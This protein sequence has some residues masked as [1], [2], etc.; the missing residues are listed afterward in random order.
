MVV[1]M[2]KIRNAGVWFLEHPVSI[3]LIGY[4]LLLGILVFVWVAGDRASVSG[5]LLE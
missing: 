4:A 2:R 1:I 3:T 5:G